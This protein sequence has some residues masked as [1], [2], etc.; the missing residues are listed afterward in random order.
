M[1][2]AVVYTASSGRPAGDLASFVASTEAKAVEAAVE[3][4][5]KWELKGF[6]PYRIFVGKLTS[7]VAVPRRYAL[8]PLK[9]TA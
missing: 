4:R 2:I 8:R 1:Y 6:G 7:E 5:H 9:E 3:A